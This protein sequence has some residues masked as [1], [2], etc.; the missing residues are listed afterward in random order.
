MVALVVSDR[1]PCCSDVNHRRVHFS[2][3]PKQSGDGQSRA[4]GGSS[5]PFYYSAAVSYL[6][7]LL[8]RQHA[9]VPGRKTVEGRRAKA[10]C[11]FKNLFV[12]KLFQPN[13]K[14]ARIQVIPIFLEWGFK[15]DP[16]T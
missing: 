7:I 1:K 10:V 3:H 14:V 13:G 2:P 9:R 12:V 5:A 16:L 8:S 4:A 6:R 11:C 15:F